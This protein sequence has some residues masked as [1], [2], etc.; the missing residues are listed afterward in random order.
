MSETTT[1]F[2]LEDLTKAYIKIREAR[3]KLLRDYEA[4]DAGLA[5]Q[6]DMVKSALLGFCKSAAVDSVKTKYGTVSRVIKERFECTD[7][8]SFKTFAKENDA[9]ELF[10]KRIHQTNM[11]Q[12]METNPELRPPGMNI[13]REFSIVV[14]KRKAAK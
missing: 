10:E 1:G 13:N 3:A 7:W 14:T 5:G 11:K 2:S 4:E 9:L 12:F 8:D 6:L